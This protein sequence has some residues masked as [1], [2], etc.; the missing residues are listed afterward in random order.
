VDNEETIDYCRKFIE[1]NTCVSHIYG[2]YTHSVDFS[3]EMAFNDHIVHFGDQ[4]SLT[5]FYIERN[6]K[7]KE[8]R[9]HFKH[10]KISQVKLFDVY[11]KF[12]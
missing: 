3:R 11:V 2:Y 9:N 7:L 1:L 6:K 8:I 12:Q 5:R 10:K 4:S